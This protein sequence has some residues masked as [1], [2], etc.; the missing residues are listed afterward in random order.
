[1]ATVTMAAKV[2]ID[3]RAI[4]ALSDGIASG[5]ISPK[6]LESLDLKNGVT[7]GLIDLV[8]YKEESAVA[9]STTTRYDLDDGTMKDVYGNALAFVE[10]V[11]IGIR[12]TRA[13]ADAFIDIGPSSSHPFGA[14]NEGPWAA[15]TYRS[16][17]CQNSGWLF[18]YVPEGAAVGSGATDAIDVITSA[19]VGATNEFEILILGRSA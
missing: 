10:V 3:V 1:M 7:E 5:M 16:R 11:L 4:V 19:V 9:A 14:G 8:Y 6:M 12:N 2:G 18:L 15:V 13:T 17:V